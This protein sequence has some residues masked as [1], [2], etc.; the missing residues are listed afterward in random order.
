MGCDIHI[1]TQIKKNNKW[2]YIP[3]TPDCLKC[4][5]YETFAFLAGV[6]GSYGD[7]GFEP[8][9]LP[10]DI[11]E[12]R[13]DFIDKTEEARK[14]YLSDTVTMVKMP[15]GNL[16]SVEDKRFLRI[17]RDPKEIVKSKYCIYNEGTNAVYV[18][19]ITGTGGEYV[20]VPA[21]SVM[22]EKTY[23][24]KYKK[25]D[26][27]PETGKVGWYDVDFACHEDYHSHS[28]L[29]LDE[30]IKKDKHGYLGE[31]TELP[32]DFWD[33][34]VAFG[35]KLPK[36]MYVEDMRDEDGYG[37]IYVKW[38]K[39]DNDGNPVARGSHNMPVMK[40]IEELKRTAE[41]YG[42]KTD[43]IRIVFCFDN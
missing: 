18:C 42:V 38:D 31:N 15:D 6:R 2:E 19:D 20:D 1:I 35:G 4:R 8:K 24:A 16:L 27:I 9:G 21:V 41:K 7:Y 37:S 43:E 13:Y 26:Y 25:E 17:C 39:I 22:D 11:G 30:L 28:W 12:T 36:E 33:A 3:E 14:D 32:D 10:D 23:F 34:F 5:C 40:A 29:T